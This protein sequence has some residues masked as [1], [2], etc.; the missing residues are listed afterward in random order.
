R[1]RTFFFVGYEA[2]IERLGRTIL[3]NVPDENSRKGPVNPAVKPYLDLIPL[4]NGAPLPGGF[5]EYFFGFKQTIDQHYGQGRI[6]H[7]FNHHH[8]TFTRYTLDDA[9]KDLP[10]DFPQFPRSFVSRNQFTTIEHTWFRSSRTVSTARAGFSRT[11]VGQ[12][13]EANIGASLPPF[14]PGRRSIGDI[15]IGGMQ[16]FGPQSLRERKLC[17][18]SVRFTQGLHQHRSVPF[19]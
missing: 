3:S 17:K 18:K 7:L 10:T 13:V 8:H 16:R 2:L 1:D 9:T 11:R 6:D 15:D 5:G 14:V 4:P 12:E 19:L